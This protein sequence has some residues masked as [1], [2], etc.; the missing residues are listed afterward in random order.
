MR[1][2]VDNPFSPGSDHLPTVWAGRN[3][4][5]ADWSNVVRPRRSA[6]IYERGRTFLGEAGLGKSTL[7]RRI[8]EMA[9]SEGDWVSSQIRLP[10]GSDPLKPIAKAVLNLADH[11][12]LPASREQRVRDALDRVRTV[13]LKGISLTLD[14]MPGPEPYEALT[15]LLVEIGIAAASANRVILIHIDEVQNI[16]DDGALS[17]LLIALGDALVYEY[18]VKAPGDYEISRT[19]P[20]VIYLTG[21]PEFAEMTSARK[22]ATFVRRFATTTLAPIADEDLLLALSTFRN[23]GWP[24]PNG[25]GGLNYIR[26]T[27]EAAERIVALSKGE[28]FLFQ[29]AGDRAWYQS[30]SDVITVSDV[31]SGWQSVHAEAAAHVERILDRLPPRERQFVDAMAALAPNSRTATMIAKNMGLSEASQVGPL[32]QRLDTTRGIIERG[33]PY[34][35]RHR[36]IEAYLTSD[37]PSIY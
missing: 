31:N 33:R 18:S 19:L 15:Q 13:A 2:A 32:A 34:T 37:W 6:G 3:E 24:V 1:T 29:L 30:C 22:G 7:V 23:T 10:A 35:F 26:M 21:L 27:Q 16:S 17:Q 14:R 20:L 28:P 5:L 36:A 9:R 11:A 4:Q 12:G 8:A 25:I